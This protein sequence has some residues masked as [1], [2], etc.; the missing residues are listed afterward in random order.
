[1]NTATLLAIAAAAGFT[2]GAAAQHAPHHEHTDPNLA[3]CIH[4]EA[5]PPDAV[6]V[7]DAPGAYAHPDLPEGYV[8]IDGD[9]QVRL[10]DYRAYLAGH[11]D[12]VFGDAQF[13]PN[14]TVP[15]DFVTS[16]TGAVNATNQQRAVDA[17]NAIAARTGLTFRPR[18][19]ADAAWIRFQNSTGNSSPVGRQGGGQTI[20]IASWGTQFVIIH[21]IYHSLGFW[22]QQSAPNRNSYV[23][24]NLANVEPGF[25]HNF[26]I[27]SNA[28]IY[29]DYDFDSFMHYPRTAFSVNGLDTITVLQPWNAQ[30]Q[31]AI[32]QRN[33]FSFWD[34][35]VCRGIYRF[36][37]DYWWQSGASGAGTLNSPIGGSLPSRMSTLPAGSTLFIKQPGNYSAVG[38]YSNPITIRA[39]LGATLGN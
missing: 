34:E 14:N 22:H 3:C 2:A 36:P 13:W 25:E 24:I 31:N 16:G 39:P 38:T 30:W 8:L 28:S 4:Y 33:H 27:R 1:M 11:G 21:E 9:I 37:N 5:F 32:G 18:T 7:V 20:N 12:A 15:F 19:G 29:G 17:M 10:D 23:A 35:I 26:Q 6:P